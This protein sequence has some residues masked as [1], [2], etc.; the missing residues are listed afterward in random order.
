[1]P[2]TATEVEVKKTTATRKPS[3]TVRNTRPAHAEQRQSSKLFWIAAPLALVGATV[4]AYLVVRRWLH[5]S[6]DRLI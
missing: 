5:A 6:D 3:H 1:M 2:N 4:A